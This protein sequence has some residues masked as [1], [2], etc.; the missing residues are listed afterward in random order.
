MVECDFTKTGI[1]VREIACRFSS[2]TQDGRDGWASRKKSDPFILACL[3]SAC[4]GRPNGGSGNVFVLGMNLATLANE[5]AH[6]GRLD[7]PERRHAD[8]NV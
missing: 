1:A 3:I 8:P 6:T 7:C 5:T 4:D 2:L